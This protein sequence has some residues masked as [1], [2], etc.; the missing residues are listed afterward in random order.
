MQT[1]T[2]VAPVRLALVGAGIFMQDAHVPS[3]L[4]QRERFEIVAVYSRSEASAAKVA[5]QLPHPV[6]IFTDYGALLADPTIEAVDI[7]LPIP[8]IGA[9]IA[10]ALAAGKAVISEKPIAVD[11]ATARRLLEIHRTHPGQPWMVG[12]NWRYETAF[13]E[14]AAMIRS[15]QI[16][17]PVTAHCA[18]YTPV[19]PGSKYY[20]SVWRESGEL[21]GGYLLDGGVH[22]VAAL[23][24]L[25]GEIQTVSASSKQVEPRLNPA[26]TLAA[27]LRFANGAVGTYLVSYGVGVPWPPYFFVVGERGALC[28]QRGEVEVTVEGQTQRH[29]YPKYDGVEN[30]LI[31]FADA[32]RTGAPYANSPQEALCDLAVVEALLQAAEQGQVVTVGK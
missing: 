5:Q 3:L 13:V 20:G 7:A 15:G 17:T 32:V 24:M 29:T 9:Y 22:H 30:E 14:A 21:P 4:R 6:R 8:V 10:E 1:N 25:V 27:Q 11:T 16:G 23:R 18:L 28:V 2:P 12:E 31:A 26:D 19:L